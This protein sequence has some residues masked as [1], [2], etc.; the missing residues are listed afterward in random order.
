[1]NNTC[2]IVYKTITSIIFCLLAFYNIISIH[3][4]HFLLM[5]LLFCLVGDILLAYYNR[6]KYKK[7]FIFGLYAFFCAH[8][9]FVS[10]MYLISAFNLIDLLLPLLSVIA[11]YWLDR[12]K[13]IALKGMRNY[14][15]IYSLFVSLLMAKGIDLHIMFGNAKSLAL[16]SGGISFFVSDLLILFLYFKKS[17][18]PIHFLN[19]ATYYSAMYLFSISIII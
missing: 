14:C 17:T 9:G 15:L 2:Y 13:V 4:D 16:M 18:R 19:L 11:V 8:I 12:K 1:M 5:P 7:C 10:H 6:R 3:G